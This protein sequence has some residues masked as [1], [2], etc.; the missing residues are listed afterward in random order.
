[1]AIAQYANWN[2]EF[3]HTGFAEAV[4]MLQNNELDLVNNVSI[5]EARLKTLAF[6]QHASGSNC[7]WL[8]VNK[9]NTTYAHNDFEEFNNMTVGI[10]ATSIFIP[11]FKEFCTKHKINPKIVY[12]KNDVELIDTIKNGE[13]DAR[14]VSSS[15]DKWY[16]TVA[17][18]APMD[19]YFAVPINENKLIEELDA[20]MESLSN[21]LPNFITELKI[22]YSSNEIDEN[23]VFSKKEK[24][25][26]KNHESIRVGYAEHWRPISY[27][28]ENGNFAGA[29]SKIY[30]RL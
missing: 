17:E 27:T 2:L 23:I 30:A 14:V 21:D 20:A 4:S 5:T 12:Y 9:D 19:Y 26:I 7:G 18:F 22:K 29:L 8:V 16:R 15:Y 3:V 6:S 10:Y 28:D 13:I 24:E 25:Y 11:Y 1:M